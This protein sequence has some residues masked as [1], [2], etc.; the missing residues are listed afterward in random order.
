VTQLQVGD[1]VMLNPGVSCHQCRYCLEGRHSLCVSYGLLGE[2]VSGTLTEAIV[3]PE[4]NA[5]LIP[6]MPEGHEQ[7]TWAEAA[8]FSLVNITAWHMLVDRAR[9]R[10][11]ETVLIWGIGGGVAGAALKIAKLHGAVVIATSSS[12]DKLEWA[13]Q[14]G[15]DIV[16]NHDKMDV[17]KEVR[18]ATNRAGVDIVVETAGEA[19]WDRSLRMLGRGGRLVT[20]GGTTGPHVSVDVRKLFWFQWDILGSTMG[21]GGDYR[22]VARVL[23]NGHLRSTIDSVHPLEDAL[24][25]FERL[26]SG[27]HLGKVVLDI[28]GRA[29]K[30]ALDGL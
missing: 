29:N 18:A 5:V 25:A 26:T 27:S 15:A 6:R 19:T 22:A 30:T 12:E 1:R 2:H 3:V 21:G 20:C 24:D 14:Q 17:A 10:A 13:K 8:A 11:G 4:P 16:L 7:L 9:I 23:A 28:R